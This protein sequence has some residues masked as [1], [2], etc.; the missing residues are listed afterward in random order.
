MHNPNPI[1]D[2]YFEREICSQIF[3]C[4]NS[5]LS[6]NTHNITA[7][8][9]QSNPM[10]HRRVYLELEPIALNSA[11]TYPSFIWE[12]SLQVYSMVYHSINIQFLASI[13]SES[14]WKYGFNVDKL[15]FRLQTMISKHCSTPAELNL[16]QL[17]PSLYFTF[18]I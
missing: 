10:V 9:T 13:Q 6:F 17:S 4:M 14:D 18:P 3:E 12:P 1:K 11:A 16:A 2:E 8:H 7:W 15:N 5:Y